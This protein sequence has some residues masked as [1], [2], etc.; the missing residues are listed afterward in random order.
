L[1]ETV[2]LALISGQH[3]A[4]KRHLTVLLLNAPRLNAL[5]TVVD[6]V[7]AQ[8]LVSILGRF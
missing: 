1:P 6:G 2:P 3:G 8:R 7:G 5:S 4:Q